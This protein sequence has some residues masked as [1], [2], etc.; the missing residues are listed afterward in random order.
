M[1]FG[2]EEA[3]CFNWDLMWASGGHLVASQHLNE[4]GGP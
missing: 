1:C 3:V 4:N 2:L